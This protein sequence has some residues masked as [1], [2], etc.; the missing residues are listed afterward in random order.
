M[1]QLFAAVRALVYMTG[2]VYVWGWLAL[3]VRSI[4][5]GS[6]LPPASRLV[7][8]A[9]MVLGGLV[10]L[11][12]AGW[13]AVVGGGTPAP[14][15]APRLF[16]AGGPYRWVRNPMYLGAFLVLAGFGLWHMSVSMVLLAIPAAAL[17]HLFVV[18]YEEPTLRR[19]FGLSYVTYLALVSRWVPKPPRRDAGQAA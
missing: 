15:D 13:F 2:F 6:T 7:G 1:T 3:Q 4:G 12:C 17:A 16:V 9:L 10:V 11:S 18:F 5:G 14:F 19:R 8:T